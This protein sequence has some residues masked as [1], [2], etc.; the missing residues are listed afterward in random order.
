MCLPLFLP[1]TNILSFLSYSLL[2]FFSLV[3]GIP[4][5][6]EIPSC[7]LV[8]ATWAQLRISSCSCVYFESDAWPLFLL[9]YHTRF[10]FLLFSETAPLTC[11]APSQ[12]LFPCFRSCS[13]VSAAGPVL[14]EGM[15]KTIRSDC[16]CFF[17]LRL[18]FSP[19]FSYLL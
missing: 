19:V 5:G 4:P 14:L 9:K 3:R 13:C 10:A 8:R 18:P 15:V 1:R 16:P 7:A 6:C 12:S 2:F 17:T 11:P